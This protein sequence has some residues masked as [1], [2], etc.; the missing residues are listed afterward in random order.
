M[1]LCRR[2]EG[3]SREGKSNKNPEKSEWMAPALKYLDQNQI[4][5]DNETISTYTRL[6]HQPTL[7]PQYTPDYWHPGW[8][9]TWP[10]PV[11][12]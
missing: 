11:P 2:F 9:M 6:V 8:L 1:P 10:G 4:I 5:E 12:R 3:V 7:L